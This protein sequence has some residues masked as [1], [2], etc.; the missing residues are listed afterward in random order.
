MKLAVT[1]REMFVQKIL[2]RDL[3]IENAN[4]PEL[5]SQFHIFF[6]EQMTV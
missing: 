2:F 4:F 1:Y 5:V 3:F 6:E